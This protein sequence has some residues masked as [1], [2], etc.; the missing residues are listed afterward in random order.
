MIRRHFLTFLPAIVCAVF[1]VGCS[2]PLSDKT[3]ATIGEAI[4]EEGSLSKAAIIAAQDSDS[5][6]AGDVYALDSDS[7]IGFAG[8]K[9][10]GIHYGQFPGFEG[11]ISIVDGDLSTAQISLSLDMTKLSSD[12]S[13]LTG[14]LKGENFFDVENHPIAHFSSTSVEPSDDGFTVTG[15]LTIRAIAKS[16]SFPA[17][18]ALDGDALSATAE[19]TIDRNEWELGTGWISDTVIK[20]GILIEFDIQAEHTKPAAA[21]SNAAGFTDVFSKPTE[22]S[23]PKKKSKETESL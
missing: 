22:G 23:K 7:Y 10:G 17:Q 2:D 21:A 15:N 11:N 18:I 14:T 5:E 8:S 4:P 6:S 16:V 9:I 12:D 19:F 3:G 13:R 1:L 20:D